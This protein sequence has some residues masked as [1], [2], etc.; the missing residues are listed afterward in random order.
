MIVV[1]RRQIAAWQTT[2]NKKLGHDKT[3]NAEAYTNTGRINPN[4]ST[5]IYW[6][7]GRL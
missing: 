2:V 1:Q 7:K 4:K 3:V 6:Q 5:S